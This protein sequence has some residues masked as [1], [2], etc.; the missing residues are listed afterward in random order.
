MFRPDAADIFGEEIFCTDLDLVV[1]GPLDPLFDRPAE[2]RMAVG[3]APGRPYNGSALYLRAGAR[4]QVYEKFTVKGA[5]QAGRRFVGS[6]QSWIAHCLG[7]GEQTWGEADGLCYHGIA[8]S[9]ETVRRVTFF[10]GREKPWHRRHDPWIVKHYRRAPQG[11]CLVLGYDDTLWADVERALEAGPYDAVIASPEAAEHWPGA[12]LAVA[13]DNYEA[14]W[15][16]SINGFDDVT[17]C[18]VKERK[19]A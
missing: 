17:W 16:A 8:R 3:T 6:D 11:K 7:R 4:P 19:A 10:P 18:G 2:F 12:L 1:S 14:A 15:L 9:P 5:V 13:F